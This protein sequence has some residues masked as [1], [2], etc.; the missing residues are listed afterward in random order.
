MLDIMS[1]RIRHLRP[2]TYFGS[3]YEYIPLVL[4]VV[5]ICRRRFVFQKRIKVLCGEY[6]NG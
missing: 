3:Y 5:T 6:L 2:Q 4:V 1:L